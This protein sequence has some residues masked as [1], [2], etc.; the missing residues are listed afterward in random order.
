[1]EG[2]ERPHRSPNKHEYSPASTYIR[3]FYETLYHVHNDTNSY[4]IYR[5][6]LNEMRFPPTNDRASQ[7]AREGHSSRFECRQESI[8][9]RSIL[10][11]S[12]CIE[13]Y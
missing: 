4:V 6:A 11:G 13:G 5:I 3:E 7:W 10:S 12:W 1:L 2:T 8:T 9:S